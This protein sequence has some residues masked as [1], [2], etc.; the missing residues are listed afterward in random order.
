MPLTALYT[1]SEKKL[2]FPPSKHLFT[3]LSIF[4]L[5]FPK[6]IIDNQSFK[7]D[8]HRLSTICL[9]SILGF[10]RGTDFFCGVSFT[11]F[12]CNN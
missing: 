3:P 7:D 2:M 10:E 4:A 12:E 9:R 11:I 1:E 8:M 6:K 5:G